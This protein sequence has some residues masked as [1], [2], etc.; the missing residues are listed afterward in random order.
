[1]HRVSKLAAG[2]TVLLGLGS[3]TL[4]NSA[5]AQASGLPNEIQVRLAGAGTLGGRMMRELATAWATKLGL[6]NVRVNAGADPDEYEVVADRS[7]SRQKMKVSVSAKGTGNGTEPLARG[8]V[9]FW[10]TTRP[11]QE[12]DIEGLRKKGV[13]NV[14]VLQQFTVPGNENLIGLDPM[15]IIVHARNPVKTLTYQQIR[16][17][18][19]GKINNWSQLGGASL[20]IGLYTLDSVIGTTSGFCGAVL[21]VT[22]V[23]KCLDSMARLAGPRLTSVEDMADSVARNPGGIGYVSL[24]ERKNARAVPI[25]TECGTG[26]E[27]TQFRVKSD[28]YP[29]VTR[30]YLYTYPGRPLPPAARAFLDFILSAPG[31]AAVSKS[32]KTDL[33]ANVAEGAYS[34]DRLEH[35]QHV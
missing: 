23:N 7:E 11:V 13:P 1:M 3:T 16:D 17:V 25:G 12:S 4:I 2:L 30:L 31:Q 6:P 14:P 9:D 24:S 27:P 8:Q 5:Q 29:L 10:M 22:D 26:I 18:Y 28:E 20:P 32:G 21:G 34:D 15:A 33:A 35:V 19:A